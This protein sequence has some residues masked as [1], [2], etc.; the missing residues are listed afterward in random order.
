MLRTFRGGIH[1]ADMKELSKHADIEIAP[2]PDV[3]H[4]LMQQHIGAPCKPVVEKGDLVKTGQVVGE[5]QGFVS[6]SV[7]ASVTGEVIGVEERIMPVT[8]K[9]VP[10]VAIKRTGEDEWAEGTNEERDIESLDG[11][12]IRDCVANAGIVGLGGAA[13]PTHVKLT[14]PE[15][16]VIDSVILNGAECEPYLTCDY[17]LMLKY[18]KELVTALRL[19]MKT[20]GAERGYIGIEANKPDC[21]EL[22]ED[23]SRDFEN[24]EVVMLET[25]YPQGAE[26]QMIDAILGREVPSGGLPLDVGVVVQNVA[27]AYAIYEAVK[28]NR[29]LIQRVVTVTGDGV[30]R[31]CNLLTRIGTPIQ[32]LLERA[33]VKPDVRRLILGGPMMGLAMRTFDISTTKGVSGILALTDDKTHEWGACIRCGE[34]VRHCPMR[35][36]PSTLSILLESNEFEAALE[37]GLMDCKECGCCSYVCPAKR[38]IVHWIKLGKAEIARAKAGKK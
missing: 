6:A 24:I 5:A 14:P 23:A 38:P 12:E 32:L 16:T 15:N 10:A 36:V 37:E 29:P 7:H 19:I 13:F 30:E 27:T 28:F 8:G 9:T 2:L 33:G 4:I 25:K 1:P 35:L 17:R 11:A 26:N 31:P 3:V 20:V 22:L 21:A 18:P 34:C